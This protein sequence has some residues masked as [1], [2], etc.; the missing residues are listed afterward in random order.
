MKRI[1]SLLLLIAVLGFSVFAQTADSSGSEIPH[2]ISA[3]VHAL[4]RHTAQRVMII[5]SNKS[6]VTTQLSSSILALETSKFYDSRR[7]NCFSRQALHQFKNQQIVMMSHPKSGLSPT[8]LMLQTSEHF[9]NIIT[10][11]QH[12]LIACGLQQTA[13]NTVF[14]LFPE[15]RDKLIIEEP[16]I[17]EVVE[18]LANYK[19]NE[20]FIKEPAIVQ[21]ID[22][23]VNNWL[24]ENYQIKSDLDAA[25]TQ[26]DSIYILPDSIYIERL[27]NI[28]S[29]IE[30]AYNEI[31][32]NEILRY[33]RPRSK[34]YIERMIGKA[35][36]YFPMFEE[37]LDLYGLPHELKCLPIIE[38]AINPTAVSRAGATGMWQF[39]KGTGHLFDLDVNN[40]I[41]ERRDPYS[42]TYAA[43][44]YFTSLFN[45]YGDWSLALAA[46]NCGPGN[47]NKAIKKSGK[48]S[49][50]EIAPYLPRETQNYVPRFIAAT[51]LMHY[52]SEHQMQ[53]DFYDMP[54]ALDTFVIHNQTLNLVEVAQTLQITLA[55]LQ[56]LNPQFKKEVIPPLNKPYL[57]K[58]PFEYSNKFIAYEDSAFYNIASANIELN[59]NTEIVQ[60]STTKPADDEIVD[61]YKNKDYVYY[62]IKKGDNFW[63]IAQKYSGVE[64][65][66]ILEINNFTADTRILPGEL[67]KIKK[68]KP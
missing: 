43:A 67:I 3:A 19:P 66:D 37:V 53:P 27:N 56:D 35:E 63:S 41:D 14:Q 6:V 55:E 22:S 20:F 36:Y 23:L 44:Q 10:V 42:S 8:K 31:V 46:Y 9:K 57:L 32:R 38:S 61:L 49:Y 15:L 54:I 58:I 68:I 11:Q 48:T 59:S 60:T 21:N 34:A 13:I 4:T 33:T 12:N 1:V 28:P 17:I 52:Y 47:V 51:Y 5:K 7:L 30:M 65:K 45:R 25:I 29:M 26:M 18:P 50:W 16:E 24:V 40:Y 62:K 2:S 64:Y 39:M